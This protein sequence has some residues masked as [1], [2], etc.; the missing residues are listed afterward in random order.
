[1]DGT[2]DVI[3]GLRDDGYDVTAGYVQYLIRERVL[4]APERRVGGVFVWSE[5]EVQRLRVVLCRRGRAPE[6]EEGVVR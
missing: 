5:P 3:D 4:P 6:R 1:M 2:A